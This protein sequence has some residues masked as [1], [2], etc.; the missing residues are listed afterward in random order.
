[1]NPL[2]PDQ[3]AVGGVDGKKERETAELLH[4]ANDHGGAGDGG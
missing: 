2:P 4:D 1:M 3:R